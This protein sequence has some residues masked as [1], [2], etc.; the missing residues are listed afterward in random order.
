VEDFETVLER[1]RDVGEQ[2]VPYNAEAKAEADIHMLKSVE[3]M[4]DG[5]EFNL[6]FHKV[7]YEGNYLELVQ[8]SP[9]NT[10]F[11]PFNVVVKVATKALGGH[12]LS[13]VQYFDRD[14]TRRT[15]C[16]SVYRDARGRPLPYP[17]SKKNAEHRVFDGVEYDQLDPKEL[18]IY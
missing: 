12:H 17:F 10:I 1:L 6:Y 15:Y 18:N 16:W 13:Y 5:Y 11:L 4:V 9:A 2:L 8:L 3:I 14:G 7:L